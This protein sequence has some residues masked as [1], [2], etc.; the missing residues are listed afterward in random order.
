M[1]KSIHGMSWREAGCTVLVITGLLGC[2]EPTIPATSVEE[3]QS[4]LDPPF[5]P[6]HVLPETLASCDPDDILLQAPLTVI[7]TTALTIDDQTNRYFLRQGNYAILLADTFEVVNPVKVVGT[8]PL[9][10]VAYGPAIISAN[11]NASAAGRTPGPG[12]SRP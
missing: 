9:I 6:A 10:V 12:P 8:D 1:Q 5:A 4:K 11:I 3:L 7:D 2:V